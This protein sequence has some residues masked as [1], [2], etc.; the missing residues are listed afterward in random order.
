MHPN[1]PKDWRH[2]PIQT[3]IRVRRNENPSSLTP[4]VRL[5]NNTPQ[6]VLK[7]HV[8][9]KSHAFPEFTRVFTDTSTTS[10]IHDAVTSPMVRDF[11]HGENCTIMAYG[12]TGS[13]K[14]F[15]MF[16]ALGGEAK[17]G[18]GSRRT[19]DDV[20][21]AGLLPLCIEEIFTEIKTQQLTPDKVF[22]VTMSIV[23]IYN[24]RVRDLLF[25]EPHSPSTQDDAAH[26]PS[27]PGTFT[28]KENVQAFISQNLQIYAEKAHST[29]SHSGSYV[30]G[31][32]E[33]AVHDALEAITL[34]NKAQSLRSKAA[35]VTNE[36]SSR[37][38]CVAWFQLTRQNRSSLTQ[39]QSTFHFV[40]LA[41]SE[42][43]DLTQ[44]KSEILFETKNINKSL[45]CL[46][47]VII[48]L[49]DHSK[50]SPGEQT[51]VPYRNS[52]LTRLLKDSFGGNSKT[53][54]VLCCSNA[55][56]HA[57]ETLSTLRFGALTRRV[58]NRTT[59]NETLTLTQTVEKIRLLEKEI[60]VLRSNR[61]D[62]QPSPNPEQ[63]E[64]I[65]TPR[66]NP[67]CCTVNSTST[68]RSPTMH[69]IAYFTCPPLAIP[70][71]TQTIIQS[72]DSPTAYNVTV[73]NRYFASPV[74]YDQS[75]TIYG[76]LNDFPTIHFLVF[77]KPVGKHFGAL[78]VQ[79]GRRFYLLGAVSEISPRHA[80]TPSGLPLVWNWARGCAEEISEISVDPDEM[81]IRDHSI[82]L[83]SSHPCDL[84]LVKPC[85][86]GAATQGVQSVEGKIYRLHINLLKSVCQSIEFGLRSLLR[87]CL[88]R[89]FYS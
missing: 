29:K 26:S 50:R 54:I 64:P 28:C 11:M 56:S 55:E 25:D 75:E 38:H 63:I 35:T 42:K 30:K 72:E 19:R 88:P 65:Q 31:C 84:P 8:G 51:C 39:R 23:E 62:R 80:G 37:G 10:M 17:P 59:T 16:G 74:L 85:F 49:S 77:Q 2:Q 66:I 18:K 45:S 24:E 22:A 61:G 69:H 81:H 32:R 43:F 73:K 48:A 20:S 79:I 76:M 40:D 15:T 5:D 78:L 47:A 52:K 9:E 82:A 70:L 71:S 13:G 33:I 14:T 1:Q 57:R 58:V 27:S 46:T 21:S 53:A 6:P 34:V 7:V 44:S 89:F 68:V 3:F 86:A 41:G 87:A 36:Q 67:A 12:Q 4:C 60:D 83:P